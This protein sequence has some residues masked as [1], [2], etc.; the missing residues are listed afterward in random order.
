MK[1]STRVSDKIKKSKKDSKYIF[2]RILTIV[3]VKKKSQYI[4][5]I[6]G[7]NTLVLE[8]PDDEIIT[9][10]VQDIKS[11]DGSWGK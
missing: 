6:L 7:L 3:S 9:K 10:F 1:P 4:F 2:L 5:N 8:H 11:I